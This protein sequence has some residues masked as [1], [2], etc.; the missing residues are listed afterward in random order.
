MITVMRTPTG[1]SHAAR[2]AITSLCWLVLG[3]M[4]VSAPAQC[5]EARRGPE[6]QGDGIGIYVN[7]QLACWL[8]LDAG[9]RRGSVSF[10]LTGDGRS[11]SIGSQPRRT[12]RPQVA[13]RVSPRTAKCFFFNGRQ[14]CE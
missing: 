10:S 11:C 7:G 6:L 12:P 3:L 2:R 13:L 14:F 9:R 1:P 5:Q 8:G 4:L